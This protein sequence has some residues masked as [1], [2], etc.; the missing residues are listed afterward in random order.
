MQNVFA[1]E[2]LLGEVKRRAADSGHTMSETM[3]DLLCVSLTAV[4]AGFARYPGLR[5]RDPARR[6][7]IDR[8]D[9]LP[10]GHSPEAPAIRRFVGVCRPFSACSLQRPASPRGHG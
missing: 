9:T 8:V 10:G 5:W 6:T 4:P 2:E 1:T 3:Q 7:R